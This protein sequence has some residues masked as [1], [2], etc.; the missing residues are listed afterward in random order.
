MTAW[1][2]ALHSSVLLPTES[3]ATQCRHKGYLGIQSPMT[4]GLAAALHSSGLTLPPRKPR[5][6]AKGQGSQMTGRTH[7]E[8][9]LH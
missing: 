8:S 6:T 5:L 1:L 4:T 7:H 2:A 9:T 3:Q